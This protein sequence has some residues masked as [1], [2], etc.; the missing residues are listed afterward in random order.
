[1]R[2]FPR[3]LLAVPALQCSPPPCCTCRAGTIASDADP[4]LGQLGK[5]HIPASIYSWPR[6][7]GTT[8]QSQEAHAAAPFSP[9]LFLFPLPA[10]TPRMEA[11]LKIVADCWLTVG[12]SVSSRWPKHWARFD[13]S[14]TFGPL[15]S[16]AHEVQQL[17]AWEHGVADWPEATMRRLERCLRLQSAAAAAAASSR[18]TSTPGVQAAAG[19]QDVAAGSA[20]PQDGDTAMAGV[21]DGD[22]AEQHSDAA[23]PTEPGRAASGGEAQSKAEGAVAAAVEEGDPATGEQLS[24]GAQEQG[25]AT[26]DADGAP[27][28]GGPGHDRLGHADEKQQA[29][30]APVRP[31]WL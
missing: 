12:M 20:K 24:D 26:G 18:D 21:D 4:T 9:S 17:L 23:A 6:Q 14:D 13:E 30:D 16:E 25:K 31:L 28:T 27:E 29:P 10:Y 5:E 15:V 3:C 2:H 19:K 1:M 11:A 7:P 8:A 22:A